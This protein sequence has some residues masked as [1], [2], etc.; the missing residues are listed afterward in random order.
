MHDRRRG[1]WE[2][3]KWI[4]RY[5]K[6]TIDVGL[7]FKKDFTSKQECIEYDDFDHT[8]DLDKCQSTTDMCLYCPKYR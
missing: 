7:V 5:I 6:D 8:G 1:H 2:A 3:V 4:L